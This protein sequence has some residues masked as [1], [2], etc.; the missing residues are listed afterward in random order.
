MEKKLNV[1]I[2]GTGYIAHFHAK[3]LLDQENVT[4]SAVCDLAVDKAQE[5]ADKYGVADVFKSHKELLQNC[6]C[7]A[8]VLCLPNALHVP[9]ALDF[10]RAG[11]DVFIEKPLGVNAAEGEMLKSEMNDQKRI[12]MI[13]HMWRFDGQTQ[14]VRA[15]V[16]DGKIGEVVK[17]K[18]CGIH[19]DWGPEGW[20]TQKKLAGGGALADM[21]VHAIDTVRYILGD[22]Q[23]ESVYAVV[24]TCFGKYD[25][26][27]MGMIVI[28]WENGT[29]SLIESGWWHPHADGPEASTQLI[30]TKGYARLYPTSVEIPLEGK[31]GRE[32]TSLSAKDE[33]CDQPMYSGQ[34]AHFVERIRTRLTPCPGIDEGLVVQRIVDAAY[35]SSETGEVVRF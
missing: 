10:I 31:E 12:I 28:R 29:T 6:A 7:D 26:D 14:F 11:K 3:G 15:A 27:D 2:V 24:K 17:T 32:I 19:V 33:H 22:P 13:G 25:V 4:I 34:M 1:A 35:Q 8:V 23:P 20:F 9:V 30:G 21:G 5:F 18:G 16:A